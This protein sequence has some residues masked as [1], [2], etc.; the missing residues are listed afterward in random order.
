MRGANTPDEINTGTSCDI[1]NLLRLV[2]YQSETDLVR[3]FTNSI[4]FLSPSN[5]EGFGL[6][7]AEAMACGTPA[8]VSN[9]GAFPEVVS[10][11]KTGFVLPIDQGTDPWIKAMI[12]LSDDS[13]LRK[14]YGQA[15]ESR[16]RDMF[17]WERAGTETEAMYQHVVDR[18]HHR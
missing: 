13:A 17:T 14:S 1:P 11:H 3:M 12:K 6:A 4:A 8:I 7:V 15:A 18:Y 9:K 10:H 5:M 2:G 16:V